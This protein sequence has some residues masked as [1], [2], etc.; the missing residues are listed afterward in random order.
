VK[1]CIFLLILLNQFDSHVG[2]F[3]FF[4]GTIH[5]GIFK[6]QFNYSQC[7][8]K[9]SIKVDVFDSTFYLDTPFF[10]C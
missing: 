10:F 8:K 4:F 1:P 5:V 6:Y 7:E 9:K 2:I 3:Y